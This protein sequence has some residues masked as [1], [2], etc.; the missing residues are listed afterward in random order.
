MRTFIIAQHRDLE[1]YAAY[2]KAVLPLNEKYG[3]KI[4]ND[5]DNVTLLE[6]GWPDDRLLIIE[7]K[8]RAAA[9]KFHYSD[10]YK[11]VKALRADAPPMTI[12]MTDV[13]G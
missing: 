3:L 13:P 1:G 4:I 6:G 9:E 12:L 5:P 2:R 7:F 10:E 8:D 11:A